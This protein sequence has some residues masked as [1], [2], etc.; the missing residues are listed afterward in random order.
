MND[1]EWIESEENGCF[2]RLLP[3][4][5]RLVGQHVPG[6]RSVAL[7]VWLQV[8]GRDEDPG[9]TGMAHFIEHMVFKGTR[10]R[11][12]REI[13]ESL[14]RVGGSLDA[15]TTKDLTCYYARVLEEH[16]ELAAEVLGDL[17]CHPKLDARDI[18][19]ERQVVLEELRTAEDAPEELIGE[20]AQ[21]QLWPEDPLGA[22]ILGTPE[23]L[24]RVTAASV[25]EFHARHYRA[26]RVVVS[27]AGAVDPDDLERC[28]AAHL[29]LPPETIGL[30]R[31]APRATR[32]TLTLHSAD[33]SQLHLALVASAPGDEDPTR[34]AAQLLADILGGGMSSRLFQAVRE[35][36]GLA[37]AVQAFTEQYEDAGLFGITLAVTPERALEALSRTRNEVELLRHEGLRPGELEG[38]KAQVR[39]S[40]IM[41]LESL[42][43]RMSHFARGEY[44]RGGRESM[45]QVLREF[46]AITEEDVRNAAQTILDPAALNLVALGP[47][48]P[49]QLAFCDFQRVVEVE[50]T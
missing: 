46:E 42:T 44:R 32:G 36:E 39:G 19:L 20:L 40:F 45:E 50:R 41:G 37:Y 15:F 22:N 48:T 6:R 2:R 24:S 21:A 1:L 38:A 11:T 43:N 34:R 33:L 18:E 10:A 23:S 17:V 7:G 8:G 4:G 16:V 30:T 13:A 26:G 27:A 31:R 28:F 47:A 12:A 29:R 5:A 25:S 9:A 3:D 35:L 14:E 49:D